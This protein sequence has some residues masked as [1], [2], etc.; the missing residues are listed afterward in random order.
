MRIANGVF[1]FKVPRPPNPSVPDGGLRYTLVYAVETLDGYVLI[2]A[3]DNT[4]KG[5][6]AF[7]DQLAKDRIAPSDIK[8]NV[9]THGHSDHAGLANR[10][11]ELT[12]ARL[13]MHHLDANGGEF[14]RRMGNLMNNRDAARRWAQRSGIPESEIEDESASP[15]HAHSHG[16]D[17]DW[18]A[19]V[20]Q[21]DVLLE[22]GEELVEGSGLWTIWTPGHSAGHLCIHDRN[23]R[24]LFSGDHILPA[25]T[26]HVSLYPG[27]EG[28]PLALFLKAHRQI[29]DLDVGMVHP[30]HEYSF[31]GLRQRVDQILE[32]HEERMN[33]ML[34]QVQDG[35]KTA[36]QIASGISWNVAPWAELGPGTR[37]AALMETMSHLQYMVVEGKLAQ[38]EKDSVVVY[39]RP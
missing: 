17:V 6:H 13:A 33:E 36:W 18:R 7:Q 19:S 11:K 31:P 3:G 22:G 35:P 38:Q 32:H 29:R 24:L 1:Q 21:V 26:P 12:G 4:D 30:A 20:P 9:I 39:A 8:L 16:H 28:N 15:R 25:I 10:I 2:D 27:D 34:A 37:H 5:F 23:R 14:F